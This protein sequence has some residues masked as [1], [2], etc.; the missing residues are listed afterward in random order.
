MH[1]HW[2]SPSWMARQWR[3]KAAYLREEA[4]PGEI[5][6]R[7]RSTTVPTFSSTVGSATLP[8]NPPPTWPDSRQIRASPNGDRAVSGG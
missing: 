1:R 5:S 8:N 4:I 7:D 2:C 3:G 6:R